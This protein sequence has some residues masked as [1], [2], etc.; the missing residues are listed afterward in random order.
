MAQTWDAKAA[1]DIV[2]R[3]WAVPVPDG[4]SVASIATSATGVTVDLAEKTAYNLAAVT[5]SAGAAGVT[6]SV[7]VTVITT[8]GLSLSE[9]FYI[10]IRV[11]TAALVPTLRDICD[12]ALRKIVGN[13]EDADAAELDDAVERFNDMVALWSLKGVDIGLS[14]PLAASDT[15]TLP[16]GYIAALK[17]NL[18]VACHDHYDAP[19]TAYDASMADATYR[20][21]ANTLVRFDDL[22]M[23]P[24]LRRR[25]AEL[26]EL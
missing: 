20:V 5:L 13:G 3:T 9:T 25:A 2:L 15:V 23:P 21:L 6:G 16:D 26:T 10:P 14:A 7:L 4:D 18:R 8:E 11:S 12:F 17:F 24:I 1:A 19:I 22:S